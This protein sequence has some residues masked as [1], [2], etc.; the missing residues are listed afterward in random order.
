MILENADA[1]SSCGVNSKKLIQCPAGGAGDPAG[2]AEEA[3][4]P[5]PE[6]KCPQWKSTDKFISKV[7]K[8]L[9]KSKAEVQDDQSED[10][11]G[12]LRLSK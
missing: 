11:K 6:S 12:S 5:P 4:V 8:L 2:E 7:K 9:E 1:F 3:P 10:L